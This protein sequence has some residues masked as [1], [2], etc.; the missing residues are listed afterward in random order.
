MS[1]TVQHLR[2]PLPCVAESADDVIGPQ[3]IDGVTYY[4]VRHERNYNDAKTWCQNEYGAVLASPK[5]AEEIAQYL[6]NGIF[7]E[8]Q[9]GEKE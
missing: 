3:I 6:P 8:A 9:D 2:A 5:S 1:I 4:H 7:Y